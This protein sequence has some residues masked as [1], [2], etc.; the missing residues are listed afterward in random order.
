ML[1]ESAIIVMLPR[2]V[3]ITLRSSLSSVV[4][5]FA[6]SETIGSASSRMLFV[7]RI[8]MLPLSARIVSLTMMFVTETIMLPVLVVT[9]SLPAMTSSETV[10]VPAAVSDTFPAF[11]VDCRATLS[12][13]RSSR[14]SVGPMF[15]TVRSAAV[16]SSVPVVTLRVSA[17]RERNRIRFADNVIA[18]TGSTSEP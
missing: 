4:S 1:S 13:S 3:V 16:A 9:R 6:S 15:V 12:Q 2:I 5:P 18:P 14:L 10:T 17:S 8:V 7:A 11:V